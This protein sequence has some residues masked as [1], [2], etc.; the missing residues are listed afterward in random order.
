MNDSIPIED[1]RLSGGMHGIPY[2][3]ELGKTASTH[4]SPMCLPGRLQKGPGV[5]KLRELREN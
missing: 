5:E 1:F 2:R 4:L 3:T